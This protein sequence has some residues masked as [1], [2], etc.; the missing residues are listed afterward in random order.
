[1]CITHT[2]KLMYIKGKS[3]LESKAAGLGDF[4]AHE[5]KAFLLSSSCT[6]ATF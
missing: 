3:H 5:H 4:Q 1:M 2:V 6:R